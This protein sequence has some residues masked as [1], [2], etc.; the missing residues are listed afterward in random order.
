MKTWNKIITS[1]T[2]KRDIFKG[3][4]KAVMWMSIAFVAIWNTA[5]SW[6]NSGCNVTS[7]IVSEAAGHLGVCD[8]LAKKM[9]EIS[10]D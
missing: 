1:E 10:R 8:D 5:K 2:I 6:Y 9:I 7:G 3:N 4:V